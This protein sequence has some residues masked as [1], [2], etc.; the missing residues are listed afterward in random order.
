METPAS[1]ATEQAGCRGEECAA[2]GE[3]V[4]DAPT[5]AVP[6]AF[7]SQLDHLAAAEQTTAPQRP[8]ERGRIGYARDDRTVARSQ[9]DS[10]PL[11]ALA[12]RRRYE[13]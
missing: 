3:V 2:T 8:E 1:G 6:S 11:S 13:A 4:D 12:V 5:A 10:M 7:R 9:V